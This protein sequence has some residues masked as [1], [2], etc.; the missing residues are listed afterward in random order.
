MGEEAMQQSARR[1][2]LVLEGGAMRGLFS[3]GV[4]DVLMEHHIEPHGIV[5]VSAGAAFGCNMKSRQPGRC[6]RYNKRFARDWRYCSWRSL[7]TTGDMFGGD[8][9]YHTLPNHLDPFDT[10]TYDA[11]PMHFY[12]V[13][14][15]VDTGRAVYQRL[16]HANDESYEWI[17]ASA[18]MPVAARIVNIKGRRLLDG[19]IADSIPLEFFERMGYDRN[20]VVLTQP[21]NFVKRPG[22][23]NPL[24]NIALRRYPNFIAAS[25]RRHEM[26]NAQLD[27][28]RRQEAAG[29]ALVLAPEE[30]LP[31]GHLCHDPKAMQQVYDLGR[32]QAE[33]RIDE[34]KMFIGK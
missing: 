4:I 30:K 18:S 10:K 22:S 2:G 26:Y 19:G 5:G 9:C 23:L 12:A 33:R 29:R 13:C 1:L 11:N 16:D 3:A 15:D 6:I 24:I 21:R 31:V 7:L 34:I 25:N 8:F 32:A 28:V 14:T 27:H 20:I 17:R